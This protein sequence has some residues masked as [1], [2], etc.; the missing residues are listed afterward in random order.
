MK[1]KI[2]LWEKTAPYYEKKYRQHEPTITE[3]FLDNKTDN[4]C[5][6]VIPGGG[7]CSVSVVNEGDDICRY[8]NSEGISAAYLNYRVAP[9]KHPVMEEDAKRAVKLLRYNAENWRLNPEKIGAIG[10]SA[11]AHLTCMTALRFDYGRSD[12][13]EID[14]M[15]S[16]PSTAAACYGVNTLNPAYTHI[17]TMQNLLGKKPDKNL[18]E[19]LSAENIIRDDSPP[20]FIWH[21]AEDKAANPACSLI[22]ADALI[23]NSI[24]CE[25]HIFPYGPHGSGTA[26]N[27]PLAKDWLPL[28]VKWLKYYGY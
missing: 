22:L 19:A 25:L 9:Y 12:G 5:I 17:G 18:I 21:T 20:F 26:E 1:K 4:S 28:Y 3:Y 2:K 15:S 14:K 11:G 24:P 10:F 23:K 27:I 16:R 13:D 8:L 6:L 7:Y